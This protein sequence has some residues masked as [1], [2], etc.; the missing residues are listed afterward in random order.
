MMNSAFSWVQCERSF[1]RHK[2]LK[3]LRLLAVLLVPLPSLIEGK[4]VKGL[5]CNK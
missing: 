2:M 5:L 4:K 1:T 3:F